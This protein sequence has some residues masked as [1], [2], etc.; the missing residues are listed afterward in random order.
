[1]PG[2]GR[3]DRGNHRGPEDRETQVSKKL[4]WILR[5][6]ADKEG[7]KLDKNGYANCAELLSW[8][9]LRSLKVS[10]QELQQIV[11]TNSKKRFE[12]IPTPTPTPNAS[13]PSSTSPDPASPL[14]PDSSD[15]SNFLIRASQGHS[16]A[17]ASESL[18]T[19][20]DSTSPSCPAFVVHGTYPAAWKSI[21]KSGGL[22]RMG[23]G[24]VHFAT[25]TGDGV[26]PPSVSL[27]KDPLV[28]AV[29]EPDV[30]E[31]KRAEGTSVGGAKA[32]V[33]AGRGGQGQGQGQIVISGL[34][35]SATILVWVDVK[36][37][38]EGGLKWWRSANGVILTEGDERG[39]VKMEWFDRVEERGKGA[40][41]KE[42]KVIW[43]RDG[44]V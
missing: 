39:F 38:A 37:S 32:E 26:A 21:Q 6:G 24:H 19:A 8:Q 7:L 36:R 15:P 10:F 3:G 44:D 23:R 22:S 11:S 34:R 33:E 12:L 30:G 9:T 1:M 4:S 29:P 35:A 31:G 42:R 28:S 18:L 17:I 43:K 25:G 13:S 2:R 40:K 41:S 14:A 5:H 27:E 16:L 20:L